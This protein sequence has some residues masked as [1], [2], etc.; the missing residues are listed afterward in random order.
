MDQGKIVKLDS[1]ENMID[2]L[3]SS[4]F[5]RKKQVKNANLEDV[6]LTLT[7]HEWKED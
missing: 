4:G 2:E 3:V 1:P 5:E 6:F 7:G